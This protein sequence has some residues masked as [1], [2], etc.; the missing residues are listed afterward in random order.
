MAP[1]QLE[2]ILRACLKRQAELRAMQKKYDW[3]NTARPEQ[4]EPPGL[5]RTWLILA[6]RGFGKTRMGAETIRAWVQAGRA[7][8][9]ALIGANFQETCDI[10]VEG[11]SGLLAISPPSEIPKFERSRHRLVWPNGAT[12]QLFSG[13]HP[14]QLRGPQFD[15]A[16]ID[17]LAK[18]RS[19]QNMWD[20]LMMAL[21]LGNDPRVIITTTPRPSTLLETL[22]ED[23]TTITTR[24]STYANAANLAPGY[25]DYL[26]KTYE[27]TRFGG[28]EIHGQLLSNRPPLW[29]EGEIVY[30][31]PPLEKRLRCVIGVDPAMTAD[32]RSNTTGIIVALQTTDGNAYVLEDASLKAPPTEWAA[33][34]AELAKKYTVDCVVAEVNQGGDL[35]SHLLKTI[36]PNLPLKLVRATKDK[37][38]RAEPISAL[39]H[40]H[41]VF[42]TKSFEL[43]ENEMYSCTTSGR[44]GPS[45]DRLDALVWALTELYLTNAPAP[46]KYLFWNC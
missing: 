37:A 6:G 24:G 30:A 45:S 28:Q 11:A 26:K 2:I 43:L 31:Q 33:Q 41:R 23:P 34:I 20:Q 38:A 12:A 46:L 21:R 17:E 29:Q 32:A 40:Q 42:H 1:H 7:K 10:M 39:Y 25:L 27:F 13:N 36:A 35:V 19:P 44:S 18:F 16:W 9:I 3:N 15:A 22:I 5:W 8:R 4:R 14:E